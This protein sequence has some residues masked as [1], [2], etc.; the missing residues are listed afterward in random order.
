MRHEDESQMQPGL[1]FE[2]Q[3]QDLR[4]HRD[5]KRRPL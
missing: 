5:V 1:Q 2:Q 3:V 4:L